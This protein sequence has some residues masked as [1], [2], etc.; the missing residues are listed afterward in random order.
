MMKVDLLTHPGRFAAEI[1]IIRARRHT[2]SHQSVA[3]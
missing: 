2:G 3:I 1:G